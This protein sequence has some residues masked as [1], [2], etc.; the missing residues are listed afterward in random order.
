MLS[1]AEP[2]RFIFSHSALKEGWDNP[3]VFQICTL[4]Y[5]DS[6]IKKRQEVG[7]GLRLCVNQNGERMDSSVPGID[8]H[9]INVLT[10]IASE[11]YEQFA[12]QLQNEIAETLSDRPRKADRDFFLDKVLK[13]ARG[14]Q[15]KLEDALANKLLYTFI[16]NDYVDD[17]YKI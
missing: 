6:T 3:N 10:V 2:T 16:K 14:E 9:E 17:Q 15:L 1:F 8:V 11:S 4:K 13:N 7:R 5:S 12:K